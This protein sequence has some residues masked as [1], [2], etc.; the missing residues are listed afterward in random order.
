MSGH[1]GDD[2]GGF[3]RRGGAIMQEKGAGAKDRATMLKK[4]AIEEGA[5]RKKAATLPRDRRGDSDWGKK[6]TTSAARKGVLM[7]RGSQ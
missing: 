4:S 7:H 5:S 1:V 3:G 2:E 6:K